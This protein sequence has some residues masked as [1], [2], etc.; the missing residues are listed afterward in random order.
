MKHRAFVQCIFHTTVWGSPVHLS[1]NSYHFLTGDNSFPSILNWQPV[2]SHQNAD[3]TMS[4]LLLII[5][6]DFSFLLGYRPISL[7][8][9]SKLCR[10]R[11]KH[12]LCI[13][14]PHYMEPLLSSSHNGLLPVILT[15]HMPSTTGPLHI[16]LPQLWTLFQ[17]FPPLP[18]LF[19]QL[20]N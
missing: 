9:S 18:S 6:S 13:L 2:W 11:S 1:P 15:L 7:T 5:Y 20:P 12:H 8:W 3:P 4:I 14:S 19:S 16:L 10:V 17:Y